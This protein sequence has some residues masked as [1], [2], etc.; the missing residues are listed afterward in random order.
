M[1]CRGKKEVC[2]GGDEKK[3]YNRT[4]EAVTENTKSQ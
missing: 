1:K 4:I 2:I 3:K